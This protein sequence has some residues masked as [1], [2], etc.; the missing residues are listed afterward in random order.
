MKKKDME[1]YQHPEIYN[2]AFHQQLLYFLELQNLMGE[3]YLHN[4][5]A[6]ANTTDVISLYGDFINEEH[7]EDFLKDLKT[8]ENEVLEKFRF[9]KLTGSSEYLYKKK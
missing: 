4:S 9:V 3:I 7:Y 2:Y 6:I 1:H 8:T 5:L